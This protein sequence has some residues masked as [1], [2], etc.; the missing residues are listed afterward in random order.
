MSSLYSEVMRWIWYLILSV[1][2]VA[3]SYF[4]TKQL[5]LLWPIQEVIN[6]STSSFHCVLK[7]AALST[8]WPYSLHTAVNP[9]DAEAWP[10]LSTAPVKKSPDNW[11]GAAPIARIL[12]KC[13]RWVDRGQSAV[14][15]SKQSLF[16]V[17]MSLRLPG[18]VT[19]IPE[20]SGGWWSS[21]H[22][23]Q[24]QGHWLELDPNPSHQRVINF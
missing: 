18:K 4:Q 11:G 2:F 6:I 15:A 10:Q 14:S 20:R 8:F 12:S 21:Q 19:Y 3:L 22:G 1:Y 16:K 24:W 7:L 5:C 23:R 9:S 17:L 13:N